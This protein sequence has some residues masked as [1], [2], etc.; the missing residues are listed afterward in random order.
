MG[1]RLGTVR[2]IGD[3]VVMA[4]FLIV[5]SEGATWAAQII[6]A[7]PCESL[8]HDQPV[9]AVARV[10]WPTKPSLMCAE[11]AAMLVRIGDVM[12]VHVH[13]EPLTLPIVQ[14]PASGDRATRQID[15]DES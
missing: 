15:L 8:N 10:H 11:C 14:S 13:V 12:G 1:A 9:I 3:G 2:P 5:P 7:A 6:D 4:A